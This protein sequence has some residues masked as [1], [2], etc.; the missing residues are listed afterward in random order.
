M[1]INIERIRVKQG[2]GHRT[3][4]NGIADVER[5]G[6]EDTAESRTGAN[7]KAQERLMC[8]AI[9]EM[10]EKETGKSERRIRG[11]G[12]MREQG[13]KWRHKV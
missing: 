11:K 3:G 9:C 13:R 10:R 5:I 12:R 4:M 8:Q 6:V 1:V 2:A 7:G